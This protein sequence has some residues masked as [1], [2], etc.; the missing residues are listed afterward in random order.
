MRVAVVSG[1]GGTGKTSVTAVFAHLAAKGGFAGQVV[2]AD[3][4]VDAANLELILPPRFL[5]EQDF[6]GG[7]MASTNPETC[8]VCGDCQAVCVSA[9]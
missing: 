9:P 7:K 8:V 6:K 1:K 2:L 4:D 5:E 3:A